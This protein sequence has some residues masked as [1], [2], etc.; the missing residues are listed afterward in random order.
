MASITSLMNSSS[1]SSLYGNRNVIS[2]LASGMDTESMIENSVSGYKSKISSLQQRM[3]K[4]QWKQDAYRGLISKMNNILDKYTSYMSSTNLFSSSFFTKAVNTKALGVNAAKVAVTGK[5][6]SDVSL[7]RVLQIAKG[8]SYA[9]GTA[10]LVKE[11]SA[12]EGID[13]SED[14]STSAVSGSIS[15]KYGGG[16]NGKGSTFTLRFAE[17]E[18]YESAEDLAKA[19]NNKLKEKNIT[20]GSGS[21]SADNYIEAEVVD[22]R[23]VLKDLKGNNFEVT[24]VSGGMEKLFS[25]TTASGQV[26]TSGYIKPGEDGKASPDLVNQMGRG[27]YLSG[28][29][30]SVTVDGVTKSIKLDFAKD[31]TSTKDF[32]EKLQERIDDTFGKGKVTV[33]TQT[34]DGKDALTFTAG[35]ANSTIKVAGTS[36][37]VNE[38]L[39][40]GKGG[41]SNTLQSSWSVGKALGG[42]VN[43]TAKQNDK[44]EYLDKDGKVVDSA[45]KA[46]KVATLTIN[47]KDIEIAEDD[48]IQNMMDKVNASDAGV[49]LKY[50]SLTGEFSFT[51]KETGANQEIDISGD[52]G[53]ALFGEVDKTSDNYKAGQDAMFTVTVNGKQMEMTRSTNQVDLDGYNVTLKGDFGYKKDDQ[54]NLVTGADG[55]PVIDNTAEAVT[56]ETTTDT[57]KI[58][59]AIKEFVKDYNELV[60][61]LR[62]SYTTEPLRDSNNNDYQPLTE[63][64]QGKMSETAIKNYEE[65]AKT[66]LLY[67]DQDLS[68]LYSKLTSNIQGDNGTGAMLRS[69]GINITYSNQ[70]STINLDEEALRNALESDPDKVKDAFTQ[71]TS[72]GASADGLMANIK[73]TLEQYGNTSIANPGILVNKAGTTLSS[74]SLN[75]NE[76]NDQ[77]KELQEQIDRWQDKMSDRVDY[78][79]NQFTRLEMLINQMNSQSSMLAGLTG[80]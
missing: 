63:D 26:I 17:D 65:K 32:R 48:T 56:F 71:T 43:F 68:N 5:S 42:K 20:S 37:L 55:K 21:K 61:T 10:D 50:S 80:G 3:T 77:I 59:D 6:S 11:G 67:G 60:T 72:N 30:L 38:T 2:G 22:N 16:A 40:L 66:G 54:G 58:V 24:G 70:L 9:V 4:L 34:V 69:I 51:T 57:D 31:V 75:N 36:D 15:F 62:N 27:E 25:K 45:D 53:K 7:D 19:I 76:L 47:G 79:T 23:V 64:D 41:Y 39:G 44:G 28:K 8:A 33:G 52:L 74:Y 35:N 49:N 46:V 14:V 13:W 73:N 29:S 78:Y 12:T 18:V 1:S